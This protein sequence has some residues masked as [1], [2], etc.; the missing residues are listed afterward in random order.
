MK[1]RVKCQYDIIDESKRQR[2]KI[3]AVKSDVLRRFLFAKSSKKPIQSRIIFALP[4]FA[5]LCW[6]YK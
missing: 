2:R 5:N 1:N 6:C 3:Y 4:I